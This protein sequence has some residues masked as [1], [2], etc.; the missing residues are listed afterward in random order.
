MQCVVRW[1]RQL[2]QIR[3][4]HFQEMQ[5]QYIASWEASKGMHASQAMQPARS[6]MVQPSTQVA[7]HGWNA[8]SWHAVPTGKGLTQL[9]PLKP[10]HKAWAYRRHASAQAP[11]QSAI[12]GL[13]P[14]DAARTSRMKPPTLTIWS[15]EAFLEYIDRCCWTESYEE[16]GFPYGEQDR[17]QR[18]LLNQISLSNEATY[19]M[20]NEYDGMCIHGRYK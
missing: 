14:M 16:E 8:T 4:D 15:A 7:V 12:T 20:Q 6:P 10:E 1:L 13:G 18:G 11:T 3:R 17:D 19:R 5:Q 2:Q 9:L